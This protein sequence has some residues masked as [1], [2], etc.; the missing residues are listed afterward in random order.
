MEARRISK[1]GLYT[2]ISADHYFSDPMIAPSLTQSLCKIL[3]E[4]SPLHAWYA[5][6]RLN[7]DYAPADDTKFDIG[8]IAH[9]L[10][11]GKGKTLV[12]L[13]HEDWRKKDARLIRD[14][15]AARGNLAVLER[16]HATAQAMERAA[17]AALDE[18]G[19]GWMFREGDGEGMLAWQ[20]AI[21]GK[22]PLWCRQLL[23]WLS[24]DRATYVDYKT[25]QVSAAPHTLA[26]RMIENGWQ[27][28]AAFAEAG[29]AAVF[30]PARRRFL[31][32]TQEATPP[33]ALTVAELSEAVLTMGRK[34]V[35][36][37]ARLWERC[38]ADNVWP[39]YTQQI[40][41]P[42]YPSYAEAAWLE[43]EQSEEFKLPSSDHVMAG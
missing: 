3:L 27:V 31:F 39:A 43:R 23:D 17:R 18:R 30:R 26:R 14:A 38:L 5:H 36:S 29:L 40:V 37:A 4:R 32:V 9:Q 21:N 20:S 8:N 15:E 19:L 16:H 25:T 24:P 34:Q 13:P 12:V 10:L 28:Q 11:L 22:G 6:P 35:V 7:P 2:D 42:E 41:W 1:A 33:Y